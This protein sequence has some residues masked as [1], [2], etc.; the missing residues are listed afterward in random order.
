MIVQLRILYDA[1][2]IFHYFSREF[3]LFSH[4]FTCYTQFLYIF[5]LDFSV[6]FNKI[7]EIIY[8]FY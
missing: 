8:F 2:G 3:Y 4:N 7:D 1:I 6:Y 5:Y